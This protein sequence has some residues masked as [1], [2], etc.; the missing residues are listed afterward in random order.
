[1]ENIFEK[2]EEKKEQ[3]NIKST[4]FEIE[5]NKEL[6]NSLHLTK[7]KFDFV[8]N[9]INNEK[10]NNKNENIKDNN[11]NESKINENKNKENNNESEPKPIIEMGI[12][13]QIV[14]IKWKKLMMTM[15]LYLI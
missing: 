13:W 1:M 8:D 15:I 7:F 4:L 14:I 5:E 3:K 2:N 9:K 11:N 10:E 6:I 12:I